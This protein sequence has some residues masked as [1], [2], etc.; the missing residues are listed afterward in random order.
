M[1][2]PLRPP[3]PLPDQEFIR[4]IVHLKPTVVAPLGGTGTTTPNTIAAHV[5]F[6]NDSGLDTGAGPPSVGER[7]TS[8]PTGYFDGMP[9][10][11]LGGP[12]TH[13]SHSRPFPHDIEELSSPPHGR[14]GVNDNAAV[15]NR[16]QGKE[17]SPGALATAARLRLRRER[18][19]REERRAWAQRTSNTR[20]APA[21]QIT[22]GELKRSSAAAISTPSSADL[23]LRR[24]DSD[25]SGARSVGDDTSAGG[26]SRM[27]GSR[28]TG[29][30]RGAESPARRGRVL[31]HSAERGTA[32][33]HREQTNLA[34]GGATAVTSAVSIGQKN[35]FDNTDDAVSRAFRRY[36]EDCD[37]DRD[38]AR[39]CDGDN[40][41]GSLSR[42]AS[43][44][45]S[46]SAG[47]S[48]RLPKHSRS[49]ISPPAQP[50]TRRRPSERNKYGYDDGQ[51]VSR[52][53]EQ[54]IPQEGEGTGWISFGR[55]G[56]DQGSSISAELDAVG[57]SGGDEGRGH[58]RPF[59]AT[60]VRDGKAGL[61]GGFRGGAREGAGS[62]DRDGGAGQGREAVDELERNR[63]LR[64]A[65]DMYD[66]NGDG[67]I[68]YLEVMVPWHMCKCM[69]YVPFQPQ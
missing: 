2:R 13:R 54:S 34:E 37:L 11:V 8:P 43:H 45:R 30:V 27:G 44:P 64:Q 49:G 22:G 29:G 68:T 28:S 46:P 31:E 55:R 56:S 7:A 20:H 32:A 67:F 50:G 36:A 69:Q 47:L 19:D 42:R 1:P 17:T 52:R 60:F 26:D 61:E 16:Y 53:R 57:L 24:I 48:R 65:F 66:L 15:E 58:T 51:S 35:Q 39:S 33:A 4:S 38:R 6:R 25:W 40:H 12:K 14:R 23:Q 62:G 10:R 18:E 41:S 5:G 59:G 21:S 9:G 3:T 63:A